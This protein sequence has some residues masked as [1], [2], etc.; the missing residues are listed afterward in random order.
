MKVYQYET[1]F[2][3]TEDENEQKDN[4]AVFDVTK[5]EADL[6]EKGVDIRVQEKKL[7]VTDEITGE[8][9]PLSLH[10]AEIVSR[11]KAFV[12]ELMK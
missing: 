11:E 2:V 10:A 6:I 9:V 1:Y 12:E 8:K 7:V 4:L 3:T 5:E